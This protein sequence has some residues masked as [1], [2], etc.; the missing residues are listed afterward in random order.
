ME[1][2]IKKITYLSGR[3]EYIAERRMAYLEWVGEAFDFCTGWPA[4]SG[5]P[6]LLPVYYLF[7]LGWKRINPINNSEFNS[8]NIIS[9]QRII[10][11][12]KTELKEV[13]SF[14]FDRDI[15]NSFLKEEI[16]SI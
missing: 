1:F 6:I 2:R 9:A 4:L 11:R 13:D 14:L 16:I 15:D 3:I 7:K 5:T 12:K 10:D 8:S